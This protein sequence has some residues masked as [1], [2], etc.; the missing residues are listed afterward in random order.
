MKKQDTFTLPL[1]GLGEGQH[2]FRFDIQADFFKAFENSKLREGKIQVDLE[3]DKKAAHIDLYFKISGE[4]MVAC[5]RCLDEFGLPLNHEE[6]LVLKYAE[7]EREDFEVVYIRRD[8]DY[9]DVSQYVYEFI[10]LA[11]PMVVTHDLA[12][13]NCNPDMLDALEANEY[14]QEETEENSSNSA[15][16]ALKDIKLD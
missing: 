6:H 5:D 1:T 13:L 9:F 15:W 4:A 11:L 10:H 2:Q 14:E 8:R 16:S 3:M 7:V 12:D